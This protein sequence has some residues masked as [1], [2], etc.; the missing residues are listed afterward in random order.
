MGEWMRGWIEEIISCSCRGKVDESQIV[1]LKFSSLLVLLHSYHWL[2]P[3]SSRCSSD[4]SQLSSLNG[5]TALQCIVVPVVWT[6]QL[7][8]EWRTPLPTSLLQSTFKSLLSRTVSSLPPP[9]SQTVRK[10]WP[11]LIGGRVGRGCQRQEQRHFLV[12]LSLAEGK[13]CVLNMPFR[14]EPCHL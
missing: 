6:S 7:P 4:F 9:L 1:S 2:A 12:H 10:L 14:W 11:R 13:K 8:S 5:T 3:L